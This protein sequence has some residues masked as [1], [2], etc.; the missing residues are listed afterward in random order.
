MQG[1]N[2][3]L[4]EEVGRFEALDELDPPLTSTVNELASALNKLGLI[5]S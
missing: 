2:A 4:V 1:E 3:D 5:Y